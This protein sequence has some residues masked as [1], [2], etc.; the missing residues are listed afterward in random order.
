MTNAR[1]CSAEAQFT[2]EGGAGGEMIQATKI[3]KLEGTIFITP[4]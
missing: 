1:F 4:N 3:N 2:D